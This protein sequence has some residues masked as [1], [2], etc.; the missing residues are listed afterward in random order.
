MNPHFVHEAE[1]RLTT[2]VLGA[3][4]SHEL[5]YPLGDGLIDQILDYASTRIQTAHPE[6][7]A[8]KFSLQ[9]A[10]PSSIDERIRDKP[11]LALF[12]KKAIVHKLLEIEAQTIERA[13]RATFYREIIEAVKRDH[14][15]A[16]NLKILTFNYDRSFEIFRDAYLHETVTNQDL[17]ETLTQILTPH[18]IFGSLPATTAPIT[19]SDTS[20][21]PFS[22]NNLDPLKQKWIVDQA[23]P[24]LK[25][26]HEANEDHD[27]RVRSA[28]LSSKR[29]YLIGMAYHDS[30]MRLLGFNDIMNI[31]A[32]KNDE[33]YASGYKLGRAVWEDVSVRYNF[34]GSRKDIYSR[35]KFA[36]ARN[37]FREIK[38]LT[39]D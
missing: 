14:N 6:A 12:C 16:L 27:Q 9:A 34:Y 39:I 17:K 18:H 11:E 3:G 7:Q 21:K 1:G 29:I 22:F 36:S 20:V 8:L 28:I 19:D 32:R 33:I 4:A 38:T 24:K 35:L 23:A 15:K 10:R 25:T 30:N 2:I 31:P 37:F 5:G 13:G 26:I